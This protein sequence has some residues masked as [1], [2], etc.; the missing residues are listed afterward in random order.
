MFFVMIP[1][2]P[3]TEPVLFLFNIASTL[4]SNTFLTNYQQS[5]AK[6]VFQGGI[7]KHFDFF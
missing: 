6:V 4:K 2:R 3:M 5:S 1:N 7:F